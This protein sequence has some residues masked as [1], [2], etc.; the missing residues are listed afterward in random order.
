MQLPATLQGARRRRFA[1][2]V[3]IGAGQA[4]AAVATVLLVRRVFDDVV[5]GTGGAAAWL[6]VALVAA[7]ALSAW[8]RYAERVAAERLGQ[9][10]VNEVRLTLF[11]RLSSLAPRSLQRHSQGGVL[12]R[13]VGD[14]T[15]LRQWVSL[16]LARLL[17]AAIG[18]GG[19]LLALMVLNPLL[20]VTVAGVLAV[21]WGRGCAGRWRRRAGGAPTWPPM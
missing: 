19:A 5:G 21:G 8:L 9:N 3:A 10:Y 2:L 15:A 11:D 1:A 14:L 13:F 16:G 20:G 18:T 4:G 6:V 17:V 7:A 12:L